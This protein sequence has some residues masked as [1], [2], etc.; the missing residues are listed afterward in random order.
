MNARRFGRF[1]SGSVRASFSA[2]CSN[3]ARRAFISF[4][5]RRS[6]RMRTTIAAIAT[7]MS[8]RDIEFH[9]SV[10]V[11]SPRWPHASASNQTTPA[12]SEASSAGPRPSHHAAPSTGM[13]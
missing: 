7:S 13:T 9:I 8:R 10:R 4:S 3:S 12:A 1:V 5:R 11:D 6:S 2:P